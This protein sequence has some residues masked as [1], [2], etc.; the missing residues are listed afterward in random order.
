[1]QVKPTSAGSSIGVVVAYGANDAAEK[2]EGIISEVHGTFCF[3]SGS[4]SG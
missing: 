2:A 4:S 1:M 3:V